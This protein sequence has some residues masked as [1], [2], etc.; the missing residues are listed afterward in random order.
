M[1]FLIFSLWMPTRALGIRTPVWLCRHAVFNNSLSIHFILR[2]H[3]SGINYDDVEF[4]CFNN[5]DLY[6]KCGLLVEKLHW[7]RDQL[8]TV[9]FLC[10]EKQEVVS[11]SAMVMDH[12]KIIRLRHDVC[13]HIEHHCADDEGSNSIVSEWCGRMSML[14]EITCCCLSAFFRQASPPLFYIRM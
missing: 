11:V 12:V 14:G 7:F 5:I 2:C 10:S 6:F 8:Q 3:I 9:E 13:S 1:Q 4:S